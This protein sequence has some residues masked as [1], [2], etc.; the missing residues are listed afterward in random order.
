M[1]LTIET[2]ELLRIQVRSEYQIKKR[3]QSK[4]DQEAK[5]NV[6]KSRRPKPKIL[7]RTHLKQQVQGNTSGVKNTV[8]TLL[9]KLLVRKGAVRSK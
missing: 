8:Y 3:R 2:A 1:R 9:V 4:A 5:L 6:E 7:S